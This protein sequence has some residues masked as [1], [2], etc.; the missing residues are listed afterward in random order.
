MW[1]WKITIIFFQLCSLLVLLRQTSGLAQERSST[2]TAQPTD[3]LVSLLV[4][5][6]CMILFLSVS[7]CLF[8]FQ[9]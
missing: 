6:Q 1:N 5:H 2:D 9:I 8:V 4:H 3:V 7:F